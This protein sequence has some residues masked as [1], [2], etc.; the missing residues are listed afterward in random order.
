MCLNLGLYNLTKM[1]KTLLLN[2]N[3]LSPEE[4]R[5]S[6]FCLKRSNTRERIMSTTA[7]IAVRYFIT[8][9]LVCLSPLMSV[10]LFLGFALNLAYTPFH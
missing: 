1:L 9:P 8:S 2:C 6:F 10:A 7:E 4:R 5:D 3:V